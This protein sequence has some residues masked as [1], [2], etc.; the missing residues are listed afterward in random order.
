MRMRKVL[1]TGCIVAILISLI[2]SPA[3]SQVKDIPPPDTSIR[4]TLAKELSTGKGVCA[5]V[6]DLIR[7]GM[8]SAQVVEN[9]ILMGH[10]PCVVVRC[11]IDA[12]GELEDVITAAFRADANS[13]VILTCCI[14]AG[15]PVDALA[16]I[17]ECRGSPCFW[18][19]VV[20]AR[21]ATVGGGG[22]G[23]PVSPFRP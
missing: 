10:A 13:E 14:L 9:A 22:G 8:S 20:T 1:I 7:A 5:V 15:I 21:A 3:I 16:R 4:Y 18:D 12:G 17:L 11:A 6:G 19:N 2:S 23:I